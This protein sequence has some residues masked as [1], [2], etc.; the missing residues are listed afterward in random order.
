MDGLVAYLRGKNEEER[1]KI[2]ESLDVE[3][4]T[5]VKAEL[6]K[7]KEV[8]VEITDLKSDPTKEMAKSME[9]AM[10]EV[11]SMRH[12]SKLGATGGMIEP[13]EW[14]AFTIKVIA[15]FYTLKEY[16][17]I[18]VNGKMLCALERDSWDKLEEITEKHWEDCFAT[19]AQPHMYRQNKNSI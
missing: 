10:K 17:S 6:A 14:R 2:I 11:S 15:M 12:A 4:A 19:L 9:Q 1:K 5:A 18:P 7:T 8:L 3:E 16:F 13:L